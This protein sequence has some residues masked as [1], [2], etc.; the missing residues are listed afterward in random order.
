MHW[1]NRGQEPTKLATVRANLTSG[2]VAYYPQRQGVKPTDAKWRDFQPELSAAFQTICGY[3]EEYCHGHVDHFRPKSRFPKLVYE[4]HNWILACPHCNTIGKGEKWPASGYVDPCA[5]RAAEQPEAYFT[6]DTKTGEVLPLPSLTKARR[7]RAQ[8]MIDDLQLN[9]F[10]HLKHR[11]QW[12]S[13]ISLAMTTA[14]ETWIKRVTARD[15]ELSSLT[16]QFLSERG[17][18]K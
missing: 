16:R 13:A 17:L 18:F 12:L 1:V 2:W 15:A 8:K 14:D 5:R 3:C 9:A 4:W 11:V 10:A 7:N 6:F